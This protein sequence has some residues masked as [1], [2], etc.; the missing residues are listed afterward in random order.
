MQPTCRH[1][2]S[3]DPVQSPI[4]HHVLLPGLRPGSTLHYSV[5]SPGGG[6]SPELALRVPGG[7]AAFPFRLGVA[8]DPGGAHG[9]PLR[10]ASAGESCISSAAAGAC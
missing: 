8:G 2:L 3:P 4:L 10:L 6:F 9:R 7:T 1:N 5:G